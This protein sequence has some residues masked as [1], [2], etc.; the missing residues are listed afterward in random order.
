MVGQKHNLVGYLILP[1]IYPVGQNVR[2]VFRLVGQLLILIGHCPMYDSYYKARAV[3]LYFHLKLKAPGGKLSRFL[4][5]GGKGGGLFLGHSLL[6][7]K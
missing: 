5:M 3:I 7:I 1:R 2:C 6:I 4:K